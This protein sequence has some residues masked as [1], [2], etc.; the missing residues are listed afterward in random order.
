DRI[1]VRDGASKKLLEAG[2]PAITLLKKALEHPDPEL[3]ARCKDILA[4]MEFAR[5][6]VEPGARQLAGAAKDV[7]AMRLKAEGE[8]KFYDLLE[9]GKIKD[10]L[11]KDYFWLT[12]AIDGIL[13]DERAV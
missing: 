8:E 10:I 4:T 11:A 1:E 5:T 13:S 9:R 6:K 7:P 2:G 12:Y 3:R